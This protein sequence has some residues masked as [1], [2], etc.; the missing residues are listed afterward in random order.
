MKKIGILIFVAAL[1]IGLVVSNMFS[2]GRTSGKLF[3]FSMNFGGVHGSGNVITEKRE[4]SG[5]K[6]VNVG[7]VY[8]VEIVA[9]KEFRVEIEG[10]DN[11][12]PLITTEVEGGIL[13]IEA[14]HKIS[15]K[16]RI[17]IRISAPDIDN[18]EVSGAAN[19]VLNNIKN[20]A[21]NIGSSGAS[22]VSVAGETVKLTID[23]SGATKIDA[24]D[25]KAQNASVDASG[26]SSVSVDVADRLDI[27]ASGASRISYAGTPTS[28]QKKISGASSVSPR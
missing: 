16:S 2:F 1:V 4:V 5:F 10:D 15:P 27:D 8:Q 7:G 22:K 9:Q 28:V 6:G 21:L 26:A 20:S 11:L 17:L 19:V 23:V 3:N 14:A 18:L 13:K 24:E 25:L 12:L